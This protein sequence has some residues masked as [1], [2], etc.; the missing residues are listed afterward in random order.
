MPA[1]QLAVLKAAEESEREL[2]HAW[3]GASGRLA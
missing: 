2:L 1:G 3:A